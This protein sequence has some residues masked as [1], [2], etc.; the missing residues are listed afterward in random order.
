MFSNQQARREKADKQKGKEKKDEGKEKKEVKDMRDDAF[1]EFVYNNIF[2]ENFY[3][4]SIFSAYW[5]LAL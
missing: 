2:Y 3:R 4:V 5:I 1:N